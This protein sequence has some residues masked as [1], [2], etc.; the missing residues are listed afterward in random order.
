VKANNTSAVLFLLF[1]I[2]ISITCFLLSRKHYSTFTMSY[3]GQFNAV[4][5]KAM[6]STVYIEISGGLF[7]RDFKRYRFHIVIYS[8]T[9]MRD[10]ET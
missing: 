4:I 2:M 1:R 7:P 6:Q 8:T 3:I 5:K 10:S 9:N